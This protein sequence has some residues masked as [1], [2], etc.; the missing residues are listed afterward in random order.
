MS[1]V[2]PYRLYT[3]VSEQEFRMIRRIC[4]D[5]GFKSTYKLMQALIRAL[6]RYAD[7][8]AYEEDDTSLGKEVEEMFDEM[9]AE[10]PR[11]RSYTTDRKIR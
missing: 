7:T 5:Y 3:K 1:T 11:I 8:G 2:H 6:L 4:A 10:Q 9:M